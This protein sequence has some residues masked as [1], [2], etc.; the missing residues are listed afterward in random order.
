MGVRCEPLKGAALFVA[1][2]ATLG[3]GVERSRVPFFNGTYPRLKR[4]GALESRIGIFGE[5]I[6]S[7][8]S[9]PRVAPW[10][11]TNATPFGGSVSAAS[12]LSL[13]RVRSLR[14]SL[15]ASFSKPYRPLSSQ[16]LGGLACY[17]RRSPRG[18]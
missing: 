12:R 3:L 1:Q 14:V 11:N 16:T 8:L 9:L 5:T 13:H 17:A 7:A 4:A 2:G 6:R 10:A 18:I 15:A